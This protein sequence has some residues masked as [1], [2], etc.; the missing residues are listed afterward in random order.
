M[1]GKYRLVFGQ[2]LNFRGLLDMTLSKFFNDLVLG[3]QAGTFLL[4]LNVFGC[5]DHGYYTL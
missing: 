2:F 1:V 5:Y 3:G 4:V